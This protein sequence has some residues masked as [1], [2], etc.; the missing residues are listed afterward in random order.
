MLCRERKRSPAALPLLLGDDED[1]VEQE[2][3]AEPAGASAED[4]GLLRRQQVQLAPLQ[5]PAGGRDQRQRLERIRRTAGLLPG[6]RAVGRTH[7]RRHLGT[8]SGP[9]GQSGWTHHAHLARDVSIPTDPRVWVSSTARPQKI[10]F[11]PPTLLPQVLTFFFP[12]SS[13]FCRVYICSVLSIA[14]A[15]SLH[16]FTSCRQKNHQKGSG[17]RRE[18]EPIHPS[19]QQERGRR[20]LCP[21]SCTGERAE[22]PQRVQAGFGTGSWRFSCQERAPGGR[23]HLASAWRGTK[24]KPHPNRASPRRKKRTRR[25]RTNHLRSGGEDRRTGDQTVT[26]EVRDGGASVAQPGGHAT[27]PPPDSPRAAGAHG[28]EPGF[29]GTKGRA[30]T[31]DPVA[32]TSVACCLVGMTTRWESRWR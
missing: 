1:V 19:H 24:A 5:Q 10:F 26:G 13:C 18:A 31:S 20:G 30:A 11:F 29:R 14:R 21:R 17:E 4:A 27:V 32:V 7:P 8:R 9:W 16:F 22:S 3:V 12:N 23:Q 6:S 28:Q 2:E 25:G 15:P